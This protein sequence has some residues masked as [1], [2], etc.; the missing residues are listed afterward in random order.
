MKPFQ[1]RIVKQERH[2]ESRFAVVTN[3]CDPEWA[4]T[5]RPEIFGWP[6]IHDTYEDAE[7][8]VDWIIE[9]FTPWETVEEYD[10][11]EVVT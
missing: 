6:A 11:V 1:V 8:L 7:A 5:P 10:P 3:I 2:G 4:K 9:Y